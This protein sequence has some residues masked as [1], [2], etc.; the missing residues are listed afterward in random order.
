MT[1]SK[2]KI[3]FIAYYALIWMTSSIVGPYQSAFYYSKGFSAFEIGLLSSIGSV[4]SLLIQ[5][6]W[7]MINDRTKHKMGL[8]RLVFTVSALLILTFLLGQEYWH[9]IIITIIYGS[10]NCSVMQMSDV[11]T[12]GFINKKHLRFSYIRMSGTLGYA[13]SVFVLGRV[14]G[15][16]ELEI[17]YIVSAVMNILCMGMT[18][19]LPKMDAEDY[20]KRVKKSKGVKGGIK[21]MMTPAILTILIFSFVMQIALSYH[22]T[23]LGVFVKQMGKSETMIGM[24]Q[25]C[26]ALSE[27]P[28]LLVIDWFRKKYN[29]YVILIFSGFMMALRM[30][31]CAL[32]PSWGIEMLFISQLLQGVTYMNLHYCCI[33]FMNEHLPEHLKGTGLA[34]LAVAQG[35]AGSIV[36]SVGGGYLSDTFGMNTTY[37]IITVLVCIASTVLWVKYKK[38]G[39]PAV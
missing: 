11:Y 31:S 37:G 12:L 39:E 15:N 17:I 10:F 30:I 5:P 33:M 16:A 3:S 34:L 2:A 38:S 9:F 6:C 4:T 27:V 29:S 24:L 19:L 36:A 35:S 18:F 20:A 7:G 28:V 32:A 26:S 8:L 25:C 13:F 21:E 1:D 22:S 23:F 14:L